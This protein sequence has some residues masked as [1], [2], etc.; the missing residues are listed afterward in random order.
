MARLFAYPYFMADVFRIRRCKEHQ[1][2]HRALRDAILESS[3]SA[4]LAIAGVESEVTVAQHLHDE[5]H[6]ALVQDCLQRLQVEPMR[7]DGVI[8]SR[9]IEEHNASPIS[10]LESTLDILVKQG[11]FI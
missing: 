2:Q 3:R 6:Q 4:A 5:T 8:H 1:G 7:P 10:S 9:E 11:D